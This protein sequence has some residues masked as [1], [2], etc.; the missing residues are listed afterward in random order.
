M[1]FF[2]GVVILIGGLYVARGFG[3]L[4]LMFVGWAGAARHP[5]S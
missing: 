5:A 1:T 2:I 3:T 4:E